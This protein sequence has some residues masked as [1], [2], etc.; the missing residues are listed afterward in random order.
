MRLVKSFLHGL[1][2][3]VIF[4]KGSWEFTE[5]LLAKDPHYPL[6]LLLK[7]GDH[8]FSSP[9]YLATFLELAAQ[10]QE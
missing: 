4:P 1:Q 2:D 5:D 9:S 6:E 7:F 8:R 10:T 3:D